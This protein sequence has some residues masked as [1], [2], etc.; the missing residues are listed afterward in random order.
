MLADKLVR[1]SVTRGVSRE[2]TE[3]G[4]PWVIPGRN[5]GTH[6]RDLNHARLV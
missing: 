2:S 4:S 3:S 1:Y 5:P 6:L